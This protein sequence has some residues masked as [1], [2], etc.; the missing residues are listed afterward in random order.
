MG[1][2][3]WYGKVAGR[4]NL[5]Q[6]EGKGEIKKRR[7]GEE[8]VKGRREKEKERVFIGVVPTEDAFVC[9][10]RREKVMGMISCRIFTS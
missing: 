1:R 6:G 4:D 8:K 3:G 5:A 2:R 9:D 10:L 7:G